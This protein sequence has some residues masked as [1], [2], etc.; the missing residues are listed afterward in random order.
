M[1]RTEAKRGAIVFGTDVVAA[2]DGS[3]AGL[4]GASPGASTAVSI[5]L[6]VMR[7]CFPNEFG[8]WTP[9]LQ[10]LVPSVDQSLTE[11][12]VLRQDV[13]EFVQSTLHLGQERVEVTTV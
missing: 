6:D 12:P 11:D 10:E 9:R 13:R 3:I 4:M 7:R 1:K 2:G 5:M 8:K